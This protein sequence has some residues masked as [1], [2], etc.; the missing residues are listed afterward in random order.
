MGQVGVD[1]NCLIMYNSSD[2]HLIVS[3]HLNYI[4]FVFVNFLWVFECFLDS[5]ATYG[6][7]VIPIETSLVQIFWLLASSLEGQWHV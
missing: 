1:S 4:S 5:M 7:I 6:L 3:L 2:Q